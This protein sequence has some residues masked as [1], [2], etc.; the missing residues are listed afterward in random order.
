M[1]DLVRDLEVHGHVQ[2]HGWQINS[3]FDFHCID[4]DGLE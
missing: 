1:E 4:A 3:V 2:V